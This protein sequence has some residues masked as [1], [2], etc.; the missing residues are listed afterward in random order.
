MI[1]RRAACTAPPG[2][3]IYAIGDVHGRSDLLRRILENI[4]ADSSARK[5]SRRVL[6][7]LGDYINRG[8]DSRAV[9]ELAIDP[10]LPGFE[11]VT[12]KGNNEDALLRFLDGDLMVGA[13]WLDYGGFDTMGHYGMMFDRPRSR[14]LATLE[15]LRQRS[16]SLPDYGMAIALAQAPDQAMLDELRRNFAAALPRRHLDFFSSLRV[17]HREGNYYFVHA[18]ILPGVPLEKQTNLDRMWIRNRF[19]DSE[20]DHGVVVVHGHSVS[21]R[22]EVK[23]NRIGIDTGAYRTG[24]LTCLVLEGTKRAFLQT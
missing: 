18:G 5:A 1:P 14:D 9:V 10:G 4:R 16:D 20:L 24:V 2:T 3:V 21:P 23:H 7:F 11:V 8:V 19:L 13:H 17:A 12:L 22:P 15:G 6:V